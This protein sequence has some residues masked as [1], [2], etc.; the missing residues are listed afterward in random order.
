MLYCVC[1]V[2]AEACSNAAEYRE[3]VGPA[4]AISRSAAFLFPFERRYRTRYPMLAAERCISLEN[5]PQLVAI[6]IALL[7]EALTVDWG[8]A[9]LLAY[10]ITLE[11][12]RKNDPAARIAFKEFQKVARASPLAQAPHNRAQ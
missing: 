4:L 3:D 5:P 2:M 9:D 6:T 8:A 1:M 11:L 10:M 7:N 12:E